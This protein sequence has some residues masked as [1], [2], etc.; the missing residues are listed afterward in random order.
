MDKTAAGYSD[1]GGQPVGTN[2]QRTR[3]EPSSQG[4]KNLKS[5][6]EDM[7]RSTDEEDRRRAEEER[8]RRRAREDKEKAEAAERAKT[9]VSSSAY[10][11]VAQPAVPQS[12]AAPLSPA[13]PPSPAAPPSPAVEPEDDNDEMYEDVVASRDVRDQQEPYQDAAAKTPHNEPEPEDYEEPEDFY[14]V[15]PNFITFRL[16][17]KINDRYVHLM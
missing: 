1:T 4:A 17:V 10:E 11:E 6:F 2:Y 16:T 14:Q 8:E 12:P 3:P 13:V 15:F 7:A 5:R 9:S